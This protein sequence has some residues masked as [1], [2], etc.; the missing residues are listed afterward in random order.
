MGATRYCGSCGTPMNGTANFCPSCGKQVGRI[1]DSGQQRPETVSASTLPRP[2]AQSVSLPVPQAVSNQMQETTHI[3]LSGAARHSGFLGIKVDSFVIVF[4]NLRIIFAHQTV[5]MMNENVKRA[6]DE[7]EQQGKGFFGKWGAQ[8]GANS[9]RH[10]W[11]MPPQQVLAEQ[12]TNFAIHREQLRSIRMRQEYSDENSPDTYQM[13]FD[14]AAG[15]HKFKFGS[16][17]M[18]E[19]KKQ[20]QA[21]YGNIV[22]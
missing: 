19:L 4:T 8:L 17:N 15:K 1:G 9:G 6:R 12:P 18:R 14:M 13:E 11:E 16:L 7:A 2:A 22:R 21:I 20:I 3:V 10:Y 5:Q